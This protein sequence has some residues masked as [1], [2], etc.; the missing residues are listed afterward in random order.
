[1]PSEDKF[2][3]KFRIRH[4]KAWS[5]HLGIFFCVEPKRNNGKRDVYLFLALGTHDISIG[6]IS[7]YEGDE[8]YA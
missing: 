1:M 6:M 5:W 3:R 2:V 7:E 8:E 4:D